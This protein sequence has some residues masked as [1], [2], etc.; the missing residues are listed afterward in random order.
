VDEEADK[1]L[2]S[3]LRAL[4]SLPP[5]ALDVL[6]SDYNPLVLSISQQ[7][8]KRI[9]HYRAPGELMVVVVVVE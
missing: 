3:R 8:L 2:S 9:N 4:S 5:Q 6:P 7:E 1:K